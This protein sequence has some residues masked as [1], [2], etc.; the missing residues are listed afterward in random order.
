MECPGDQPAT[1]PSRPDASYRPAPLS[2]HPPLLRCHG[3]LHDMTS[4]KA[5][6]SEAMVVTQTSD[7]HAK[8]KIVPI[9]WPVDGTARSAY[10]QP[11]LRAH[12][13]LHELTTLLMKS[14]DVGASDVTAKDHI[15]AV[16]WVW[17]GPME[18]G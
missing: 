14:G 5:N 6:A 11:L 1:A 4:A 10:H 9:A 16:G 8:E 7:V 18:T 3:R 15:S 2:Y 13:G 12:G 17:E